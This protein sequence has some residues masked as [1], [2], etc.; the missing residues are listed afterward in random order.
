MMTLLYV[1][2]VKNGVAMKKWTKLTAKSVME[3]EFAKFNLTKKVSAR[4]ATTMVNPDFY[5]EIKIISNKEYCHSCN[6]SG[7]G[8][9]YGDKC[10][11][12]NGSG[13]IENLEEPVTSGYMSVDWSTV[14]PPADENWKQDENGVWQFQFK[15]GVSYCPSIWSADMPTPPYEVTTAGNGEMT[16]R[17]KKFD[18]IPAAEIP[19]GIVDENGAVIGW[20]QKTT[21]NPGYIYVP[22]ISV[23]TGVSVNGYFY[24]SKKIQAQMMI[25]R[26]RRRFWE[27]K[28]KTIRKNFRD[29]K[30]QRGT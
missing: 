15:E 29:D 22:Y 23:T 8:S 5:G 25:R 18:V 24:R 20:K 6:G 3:R 26:L 7:M 9:L 12:C 27:E 10:L 1:R 16:I 14:K 19:E 4:Y 28:I 21:W 30:E 11:Q 17:T 13:E 2:H